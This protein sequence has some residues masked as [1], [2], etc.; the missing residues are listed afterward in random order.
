CRQ[1]LKETAIPRPRR[2]SHPPPSL[3]YLLA[4]GFASLP[5]LYAKLSSKLVKEFPL[6]GQ[7]DLGSVPYLIAAV[8]V[9]GMT[10]VSYLGSHDERRG[11]A[12]WAAGASFSCMILMVIVIA[13][14]GLNQ[15][16]IAPPQV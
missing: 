6:A 11:G 5:T 10:F 14:P 2:S 15:Y 16:F 3:G 13:I 4:I 8:L 9:I 1:S 12:F 7:V